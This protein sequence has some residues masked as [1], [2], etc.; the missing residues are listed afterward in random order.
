MSSY[1]N[2]W[3]GAAVLAG[4][5]LTLG[6]GWHWLFPSAVE[7]LWGPI[8]AA[9]R[10]VLM[11]LPA[12]AGDQ[13][14]ARL[15]QLAD[16]AQTFLDHESLGE[17]VVFSDVLATMK[18]AD[19]LAVHK[20]EYRLRLNVL[21]TLDDLRQGPTVLIGGL[22]NQWTMRALAPLP[23]H[24][25]GSNAEEFWISNRKDP[26]N[27]EWALDLKTQYAAVNHDYALIARIHN[28][29]TGEIEVIV[30]GIGMSGT[31][32]AGEFLVDPHRVEELRRRVGAGFRNHDFEAVLSTDVVNGIAGSPKILAVSVW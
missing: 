18:I 10:P 22:D 26:E 2:W 8:L 14:R 31:A 28:E 3:M 4:F 17:N 13:S 15:T 16:A 30:A 24:F 29:Q 12:G 9:H 23:Y 20:N 1:R 11:C 7:E 32:A 5:A 21:T 19:L 27:R 6:L 25:A